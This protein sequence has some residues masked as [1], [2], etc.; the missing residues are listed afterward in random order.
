MFGAQ[1]QHPSISV[2]RNLPYNL[3][4]ARLSAAQVF[5][6]QANNAFIF[7]AVGFAAVITRC[8]T[9]PVFPA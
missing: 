4:P 2:P 1:L 5:P 9:I 8:S 7:P 6:A 3:D